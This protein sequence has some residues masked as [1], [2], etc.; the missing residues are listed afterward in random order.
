MPHHQHDHQV[1]EDEQHPQCQHSPTCDELLRRRYQFLFHQHEAHGGPDTSVETRQIDEILLESLSDGGHPRHSAEYLAIEAW[2]VASYTDKTGLYADPAYR[3]DSTLPELVSTRAEDGYV[4]PAACPTYEDPGCDGCTAC[5]DSAHRQQ[6]Q[7]TFALS[8][9]LRQARWE[10]F[11][12]SM[13]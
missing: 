2:L 6:A 9:M 10:A 4:C 11:V 1:H 5:A 3:V 8:Q 12:E 13:A 7:A